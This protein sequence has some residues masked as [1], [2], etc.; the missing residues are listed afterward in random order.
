MM[1]RKH[2]CPFAEKISI[3]LSIWF[4]VIFV[5]L[6]VGQTVKGNI[7]QIQ[8]RG[9]IHCT[10]V[11]RYPHID[12]LCNHALSLLREKKGTFRLIPPLAAFTKSNGSTVAATACFIQHFHLIKCF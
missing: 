8:L 9:E 7:C 6:E 10:K 3:V 12:A 1:P 4:D 5:G 2:S 11:Q